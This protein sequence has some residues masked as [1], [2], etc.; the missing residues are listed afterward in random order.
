[1]PRHDGPLVGRDEALGR[2]EDALT[3]AAAERRC[4]VVTVLG[5]PG[6]GKSRLARELVRRRRGDVE[7][8]VGRCVSVGE[9]ATFVPLLSALRHVE[10]AAALEHEP[11]ALLA[12]ERLAS[13]AD[14]TNAVSLG[15]AS[16]AV[17]RLLE[18]LAARRPVLLVL[19]DVHWA[20]PGL[21]DL[22]DY[23]A[24][25][26]E[27]PLLVVC[28]ARPQ[29]ARALG[30]TIVL[31]PL[32][33][34]HM[35]LVV[36]ALAELDDRK[37]SEIV[38]LAEGNP[39]FAEQLVAYAAAATKGLPPTLEAVLAGRLGQLDPE[40]RAVL[41][42][43]AVFG[44]EFT[45]GGVTA[46]LDAPPDA[47]L[48]SL[49]R[50]GFIRPAADAV[51]EAGDDA[52]RFHHV[53][54]RDAAYATVTRRDRA[55]LHER[56]AAWLDRDGQGDDALVGYHLEQATELR[57]ALQEPADEIAAL[58]GERLGLA[59]MRAWRQNDARAAVGLLR[60]ATTLLPAGERR[61]ELLCELWIAERVLGG[62]SDALERAGDDARIAKSAK[63]DAWIRLERAAL[64]FGD[65]NAS[66]ADVLETSARSIEV[67]EAARDARAASRA[68]LAAV[69]VHE[70]ACRYA[71]STAAAETAVEAY[72]RA[73][74][75]PAAAN[76]PLS[77]GLLYGPVHVRDA[78]ARCTDVRSRSSDRL[79]TAHAATALGALAALE[80]RFD[81]ARQLR[82]EAYAIYTDVGVERM[83]N[84]GWGAVAVLV[85]RRA[86][87]LDAAAAIARAA[88]D[89]FAERHERPYESTWAARL[90]ELLYW[91][92][93]YEASARAV[94][95]AREGAVDHDVYVQFLW[96]STAAKLA[97]RENLSEEGERLSEEALQL[98]GASDSPLLLADLWVARAEVLALGGKLEAADGAA[99]RAKALLQE[100]GDTAGLAEI[101]RLLS[102]RQTE[103]PTGL[104]V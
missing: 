31:D 43:A 59:A 3:A 89:Y 94:A 79:S 77:Y 30:E 42:R 25:R 46:L 9:G 39:L 55:T 50:Q 86:G 99:E 23:L 100:K 12:L 60:R 91:S 10:A 63:V 8:L 82:D 80:E 24:D 27:A 15:E 64:A 81:D 98:A 1:V 75:S 93:E 4:G 5:E 41:Q 47:E 58:A 14:G 2:L 66:A 78:I 35:R 20:E 33:D 11:D 62:S 76:L 103:S 92:A 96:R 40:E 37:R 49:R 90:A 7:L 44:R 36:E 26:A 56:A 102:P 57:H 16:W 52:Y 101:E 72:E 61:A 51:A 19:D 18:A 54:L 87:E 53:L 34:E 74:F 29:L 70:W 38:E 6:I 48:S 83:V 32:E 68:L 88:R 95:E 28:L 85:E 104:S 65:G 45:R 71:D 67:F 17:R 13:L 84:T 69:S 73:S 21:L 22:I 97:A